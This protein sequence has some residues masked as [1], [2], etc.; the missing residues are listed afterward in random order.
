[1]K[2]FIVHKE[3]QGNERIVTILGFIKIRYKRK[4]SSE[5]LNY[6]NFLNI[7]MPENHLLY[8]YM[9]GHKYYDK[10]L[11]RIIPIVQTKYHNLSMIDVGANI[12]D[13]LAILRH[14]NIVIPTL[15]IEGDDE[16]ITYLK[17]NIQ[18]YNDVKI[19]TTFL[20]DKI[21]ENKFEI[22]RDNCGTSHLTASE[23][24]I[25]NTTTLDNL[26]NNKFKEFFSAKLLKIDTDGFDNVVLNGAKSYLNKTN[27]VIFMEYSPNH[28]KIQNDNG[29]DVFRY[30]FSLNYTY[31]IFYQNTGEYMFSCKIDDLDLLQD[32]RDF[33]YKN[34]KIP[35]ADILIFH[36]N[37]EDL[38]RATRERESIL[39]WKKY[40]TTSQNDSLI[41]GSAS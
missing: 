4:D 33:F 35:Y 36:K 31:A 8:H 41:L 27:P 9:K 2:K 39:R 34:N 24:N 12:G 3:K 18:K 5:R 13:G 28:L 40:R 10:N 17:T 11:S 16:Y 14:D 26:L 30:L 22:K 29:I 6:E 21:A 38:F 19:A 23:D 20:S 7:A 1:M 15:C 37:D 32:F 25:I